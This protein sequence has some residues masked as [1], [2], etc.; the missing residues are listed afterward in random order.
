MLVETV[1]L[2]GQ[3]GF[4]EMPRH[5]GER[6]GMTELVGASPE[7]REGLG[8][9][10]DLLQRLAGGRV[11]LA[12]AAPVDDE[13]DRQ[14]GPPRSRIVARPEVE[15]PGACLAAEL[16]RRGGGPLGLTVAEPPESARDVGGLDP[17]PGPEDQAGRVDLRG[18]LQPGQ[19]DTRR[20]APRP[21]PEDDRGSQ[22]DDDQEG[23]QERATAP[24]GPG[25]RPQAV[26]KAGGGGIRRHVRDV[27][28]QRACRAVGRQRSAR[29]LVPSGRPG[30]SSAERAASAAGA[31]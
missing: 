2:G 7:P 6:D 20:R 12:N 13:T 5:R 27:S 11:E 29:P 3:H 10:L 15:R 22:D 24:R 23:R 16:P 9:E 28:Q 17:D 1:V 25:K 26:T 21:D 31:V 8:L 14:G 19:V 30:P 18:L 4:H